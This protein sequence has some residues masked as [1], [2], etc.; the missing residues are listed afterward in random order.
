M[1]KY[2]LTFGGNGPNFHN[3]VKRICA[4]AQE[5]SLF[6]EILGLTE[7][8]LQ[9][10]TEFW[11]KHANFLN[12]NRKGYGYW[13][14]KSYLVKKQLEKMEYGDLLLYAD[15]GC[16]LNIKGKD[17]LNEYFTMAQQSANGIFSFQLDKK[18]AQYSKMDLFHH[19]NC[20][21]FIETEQLVGG[22][23]IIRKCDES[24]NLVNKWYDACC[25]YKLIDDSPSKIPN[26][27]SFKEH[28]HD[29]SVWS[30]IRKQ[31]NGIIIRDETYFKPW[32]L[33]DKFPILAMRQKY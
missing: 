15:S 12:K 7:K 18:E 9:N 23:F 14:W 2:F 8:D 1:K 27:A 13:I 4:E 25:I 21:N 26:D 11:Q 28:R 20:L 19:F 29:Q 16:V 6:H 24:I 22:I 10:S 17:R 31:S 33:G 3:A 32:D 5:F 30:I